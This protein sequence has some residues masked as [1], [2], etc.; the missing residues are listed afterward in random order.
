MAEPVKNTAP[1]LEGEKGNQT[2]FLPIR[3]TKGEER[4][5]QT[6]LSEMLKQAKRFRG[7]WEF[8]TVPRCFF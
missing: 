8:P 1:S 4:L 3:E 6:A 2:V 7:G 5:M